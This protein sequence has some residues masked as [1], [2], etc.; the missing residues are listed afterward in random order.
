MFVPAPFLKVGD[1]SVVVL[2]LHAGGERH[3]RGT[4][5]QIWDRPGQIQA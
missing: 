3:L 5:H 1:N 2:D 4:R